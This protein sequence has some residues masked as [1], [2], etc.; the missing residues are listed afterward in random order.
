MDAAHRRLLGPERAAALPPYVPDFSQGVQHFVIHAGA[1]RS[2]SHRPCSG[3]SHCASCCCHLL[4][5]VIPSTLP[6]HQRMLMPLTPGP[7]LPCAGG[8]AVLKG[9]QERLTLPTDTMIPSFATLREYGEPG[10]CG[11]GSPDDRAS[12]GVPHPWS[13]TSFFVLRMPVAAGWHYAHCTTPRPSAPSSPG[14]RQHVVLDHV[15]RV[16]LHRVL[17]GHQEGRGGALP[18]GPAHVGVRSAGARQ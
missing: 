2:L 1:P 12:Q 18:A 6:A 5:A 11:P 14:R 15:V 9:I 4:K 16:E 3:P 13:S 8:Y 7:T 10:S 17:P